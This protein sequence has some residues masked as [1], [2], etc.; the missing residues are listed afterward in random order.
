M[1]LIHGTP[2]RLEYFNLRRVSFPAPHFTYLNF[3]KLRPGVIKNINTWIQRNLNN[4]YYIGKGII[5]N[6]YNSVVYTTKIGFE[7]ARES[8]ILL[9][10]CPEF[11][12]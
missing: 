11:Q 8:S 6:Q 12:T 1:A 10:L 4:R 9:M 3:E 5:V 7:D 2:N